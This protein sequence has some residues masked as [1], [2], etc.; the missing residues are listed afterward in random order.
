MIAHRLI[1]FDILAEEIDLG[2]IINLPLSGSV[3]QIPGHFARV[4][5]DP[6]EWLS[7]A[8]P[9]NIGRV[10]KRTPPDNGSHFIKERY[11]PN[12]FG[13][14]K[15]LWSGG[16]VSGTGAFSYINGGQLLG[17]NGCGR[18]AIQFKLETGGAGTI[19]PPVR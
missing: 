9:P 15:D 14:F 19:L 5:S 12:I 16:Y 13:E 7:L 10:M 8:K 3:R 4:L 6:I 11:W 2:F 18:F 17:L 1:C